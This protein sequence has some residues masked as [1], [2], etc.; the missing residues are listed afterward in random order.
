MYRTTERGSKIAK[1]L[2]EY[3]LEAKRDQFKQ[4]LDDI[5]RNLLKFLLFDY[6]AG[7]LSF[8]VE[9]EP[10]K[11]IFDWRDIILN[12]SHIKRIPHNNSQ[13]Q[14]F[15]QFGKNGVLC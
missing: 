4:I 3:E 9:L 15:K 11:F 12:E 13:K 5:P 14:N 1:E 7:S 6:F 8:P 2:L 10:S